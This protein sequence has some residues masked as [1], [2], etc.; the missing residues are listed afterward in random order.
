MV[1]AN[2]IADQMMKVLQTKLPLNEIE[3]SVQKEKIKE[4]AYKVLMK[5]TMI[6]E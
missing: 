5:A 2:R 6:G 4:Q 1:E 3:L